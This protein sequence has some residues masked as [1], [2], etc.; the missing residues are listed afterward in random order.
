MSE[1]IL[2]F[3]FC[4]DQWPH[5]QSLLSLL[6]L[7]LIQSPSLPISRSFPPVLSSPLSPSPHLAV[8][9]ATR[10]NA[11]RIR[12]PTPSRLQRR[13]PCPPTP[14]ESPSPSQT[15]TRRRTLRLPLPAGTPAT[16]SSSTLKLAK[17]RSSAETSKCRAK[18]TLLSRSVC[19]CQHM[20]VGSEGSGH[21]P[22]L[23]VL[24]FSFL[25]L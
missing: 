1:S 8:Y 3:F 23:F 22:T 20:L 25:L 7:F 4:V 11:S 18:W 10:S 6:L 17:T 19:D 2:V 14:G 15:H 9:A 24:L 13:A 16:Q 21:P 5:H 12:T